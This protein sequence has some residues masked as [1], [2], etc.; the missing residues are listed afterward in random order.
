MNL[1]CEIIS[2]LILIPFIYVKLESGALGNPVSSF[3]NMSDWA[4]NETVL[5]ALI[6][7]DL[8]LFQM[9]ENMNESFFNEL[10]RIEWVIFLSFL[11]KHRRESKPLKVHTLHITF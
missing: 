8:A 10:Y 11:H 1:K 7:N 4:N 3:L 2:L 9:I 6:G 5:S